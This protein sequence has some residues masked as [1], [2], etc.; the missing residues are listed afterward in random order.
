MGVNGA[1]LSGAAATHREARAEAGG[2]GGAGAPAAHVW[3]P[4]RLPARGLR[5][6]G[7]AMAQYSH[8]SR[9]P[10]TRPTALGQNGASQA[11]A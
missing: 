1:Q 8:G 7:P 5:R 4:Q 10:H 11:H 3:P 9:E 2:G 6:G